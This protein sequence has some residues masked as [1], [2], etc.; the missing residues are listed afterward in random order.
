MAVTGVKRTIRSVLV[1]DD[2][3]RVTSAMARRLGSARTV[4]VAHDGETALELARQT[5]PDLAIVDLRLGG[6]SGI[7]TIR[8]LKNEVP[9]ALVALVS[10]YVSIDV[11]VMAVKAGADA[12]IAKPVTPSELL[13]RVAD[14]EPSEPAD[15]TPS[16]AEVEAEH[17]ARVLW[18][19]GGNVSEAA[20]RL[21]IY[22]SS[23]QRKLRKKDPRE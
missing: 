11:T 6:A 20:R 1:V 4:V 17:I 13:R 5:R 16:L 18:D 14:D 12:V 2:D 23:L 8:A 21:G 9:E 15:E 19:C 10:G 22:R 3:E 7:D